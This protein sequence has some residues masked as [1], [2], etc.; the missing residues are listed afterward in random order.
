MAIH[1]IG[2]EHIGGCDVAC[3]SVRQHGRHAAALEERN[4]RTNYGSMYR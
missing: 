4:V 3:E 2:A 1:V